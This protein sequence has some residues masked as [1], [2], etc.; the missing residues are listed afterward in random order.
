MFFEK[1]AKIALILK[2]EFLAYFVDAEVSIFEI[3]LRI[4]DFYDVKIF[5]RT[6]S[7][8]LFEKMGKSAFAKAARLGIGTYRQILVVRRMHKAAYLR[9]P[10]YAVSIS[11]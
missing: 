8:L 2:S 10:S 5:E 3:F 1:F 6:H 4:V 11:L 7:H 9:Y